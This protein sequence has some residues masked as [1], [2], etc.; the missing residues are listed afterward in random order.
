MFAPA[1]E[2]GFVT[3]TASCFSSEG[4]DKAKRVLD[5]P[6]EKKSVRAR[7]W[8]RQQQC[9]TLTTCCAEDKVLLWQTHPL[10]S[11]MVHVCVLP[12]QF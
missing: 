6:S 8:S 1:S 3:G 12:W 2:R 7:A 11:N 10:L 4:C 5:I 9:D